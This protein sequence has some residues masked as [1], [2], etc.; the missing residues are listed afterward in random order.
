MNEIDELC[1]IFEEIT[2][3]K[4]CQ[5][6][7]ARLAELDYAVELVSHR[8]D[9]IPE[10][11]K[12]REYMRKVLSNKPNWGNRELMKKFDLAVRVIYG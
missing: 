2:Q 1:K 11:H 9:S 7:K 10:Y 12:L 3:E 8:Y 6:A 5:G 4:S